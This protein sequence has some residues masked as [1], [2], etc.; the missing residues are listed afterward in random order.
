[1]VI[2]GPIL[3]AVEEAREE[4]DVQAH[5]HA[6]LQTLLEDGPLQSMHVALYVL[7]YNEHTEEEE[8]DG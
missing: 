5:E 7:G 1:M 3:D 8:E 4:A 2:L 6:V